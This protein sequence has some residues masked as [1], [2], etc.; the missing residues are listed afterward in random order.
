MGEHLISAGRVFAEACGG[1]R[2]GRV[3]GRRRP[4]VLARA[5]AAAGRV[6]ADGAEAERRRE[7]P[8]PEGVPQVA[9]GCAQTYPHS[10]HV[11]HKSNMQCK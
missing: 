1:A 3:L 7:Q 4:G 2:A 5:G 11:S 10:Q 8:R 6:R 9:S